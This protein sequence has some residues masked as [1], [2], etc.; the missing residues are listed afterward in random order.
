M[1]INIIKEVREKAHD[2]NVANKIIDSLKGLKQSSDDKSRCRWVWELIQNAKDVVNSNG[3]VDIMISFNEE[4]KKLQFSHNGKPFTIQNIVFLIEQVST[5]DRDEKNELN[6][7]TGK[8]GTGFMTTHLLSEKVMVSGVLQNDNNELRKIELE[9][10]RSESTR[11]GIINRNKESFE[12]LKH[13]IENGQIV[14]DFNEMSF[15]TCFTYFLDQESLTIAKEGLE[16]LYVAM[17]YVF[18]F[19]PEIKSVYVQEYAWEF[20]RGNIRLSKK[21]NINVQEVILNRNEQE[22]MIYV[23]SI[24]GE[25]VSVVTELEKK[26]K[27]VLIKEYSKK[28]PRV[29]CDFPLIGT[30]DF[31]FPAVMNSSKFNPTEPRNGVFLKDV[32]EPE[33][34]DNKKLMNEAVRLY[35]EFLSY[36]SNRGWMGVYNFVKI[37]SQKEKTWLSTKWIEKNIVDEC[38]NIISTIPI[39]DNKVGERIALQDELGKMNIWIIDDNDAN[40]RKEMWELVSELMPHMVTNE[41][42]IDEWYFSLWK[43]CNKFTLQSLVKYVE[44]LKSIT[45][46]EEKIPKKGEEWLNQ[47]YVLISKDKG[48]IDYIKNNHSIIFPNQNGVFCACDTL[49][50]D[51]NI[52][53]AYKDILDYVQDNCRNGF[54]DRNIVVLDWMDMPSCSIHDVFAEI[55]NGLSQ[56][57]EQ[58]ENVYSQLIAIFTNEKKITDLRKKQEEFLGFAD[59]IFPE[60]FA[61]RH[62]VSII[63]EELLEKSI[64]YLCIKAVNEI[65]EYKDLR[66]LDF[67]VNTT[68]KSIEKWIARFID[69]IKKAGYGFLL[70]RKE[71]TILPNQ[72]GRFKSKEELFADDGEMDDILKCISCFAGYDIK[73][74]LLL[75]E[76]FIPLPDNRTKGIADVAPHIISYV[77]NNQGSV[78]IQEPTVMDTFKK[79]YYWVKDNSDMALKYFKDICDN[80]HWLYNDEEI[81]ENMKKAEQIDSILEKYNIDN[82]SILEDAFKKMTEEKKINE[83][84]V[85]AEGESEEEMLIQYGITSDEQYQEALNMQVFKENFHYTSSHDVSK[86]DY[87]NQILERAKNNIIDYLKMKPEYDLTNIIEIDKTMFIIEKNNEQIYLIARPSDYR[88]V[89][90]YYDSERNMLDYNKDWELWVEDGKKEPEKLTFGKILKLTGINKIPLKKV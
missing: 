57:P 41:T 89:A 4:Q 86:Y 2:T 22:Y 47:F 88:Y 68:E 38:K 72:N 37:R 32:D 73:E 33:T 26:G 19:V 18:V 8:F 82:I 16:S 48:V 31:A 50:V 65:S 7:N 81:A 13:C 6:N 14:D 74:E 90:I 28:L 17:P 20:K 34:N 12:Q 52:D 35:K 51:V 80:I 60:R 62:K 40:V 59:V 23:A 36:I 77:K 29:F 3:N 43:G 30:E 42:E 56:S 76:V 46:L 44:G 66:T 64:K 79:F 24:Q 75:T 49:S 25:N 45:V 78:K 71:K 63:S 54:L 61:V 69:F 83:T 10:N 53:D 1:D 11:E 15:N 21:D 58:E 70:D 5:K 9:I 39:I 87:V 27:C 85:F 67:I 84:V 55:T